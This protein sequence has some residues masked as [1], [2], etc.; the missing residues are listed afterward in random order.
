MVPAASDRPAVLAPDRDPVI[1]PR[2]RASGRRLSI[3]PE[4]RAGKRPVCPRFSIMRGRLVPVWEN[5]G[6]VALEDLLDW[7]LTKHKVDT[8]LVSERGASNRREGHSFYPAVRKSTRMIFGTSIIKEINATGWPGTMLVRD[9]GRVYVI[10]FNRAIMEAIV[11]IE[12]NLFE[13]REVHPKHLP[14]D[15][16]VFRRVS[17]L[18]VLV[19]VTH[20]RDAWILSNTKPPGFKTS[21]FKPS[22][23]YIWDGEYFCSTEKTKKS[24]RV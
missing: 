7:C 24:E 11:K 9:T 3:L 6:D 15:I 12:P 4:A 2:R 5:I 17:N 16:C 23:L 10:E 21:R 1:P 13:W 20:E 18:P 22:E 19:S 14:E 8:L